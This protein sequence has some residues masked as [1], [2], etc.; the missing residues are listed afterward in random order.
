MKRVQQAVGWARTR[1]AFLGAACLGA[2]CLGAM[3]FGQQP[4]PS[5]ADEIKSLRAEVTM[6]RT[7]VKSQAE[8]I[9]QLEAQAEKITQ[10]EAQLKEAKN[11]ADQVAQLNAG[12]A[13]QVRRLGD[14]S[15]G[16]IT[17]SRP[18]ATA[19]VSATSAPVKVVPVVGAVQSPKV[20]QEPTKDDFSD[21][22]LGV[23]WGT[24]LSA[25]KDM[26]EQT[27]E[28]REKD[29]LPGE[30]YGRRPDARYYV[31]GDGKIVLGRIS[32]ACTYYTYKHSF[33]SITARADTNMSR[34]LIAYF[35]GKFGD[36]V[37]RE[38]DPGGNT[39]TTFLGPLTDQGQIKV[40]V[41]VGAWCEV[42][43]AH[44]KP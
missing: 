40:E 27:F 21:G 13:G 38:V 44:R 37:G 10:L 6:L 30:V 12:L 17:T 15:Q 2:A 9:T 16:G 32:L 26:K 41:R 31:R 25:M 42:N 35:A 14:L 7:T 29:V 20:V 43:I 18:A 4:A 8:K 3:A 1:V 28:E 24:N 19:T 11:Q 33:N 5:P 39:D 23:K 36:P 22:F 34:G